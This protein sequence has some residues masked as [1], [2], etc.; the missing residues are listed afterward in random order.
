MRTQ[1]HFRVYADGV[2][3]TD[4]ESVQTATCY[5]IYCC[6]TCTCWHPICFRIWNE[7]RLWPCCSLYGACLRPAASFSVTFWNAQPNYTSLSCHV[8]CMQACSNG[9]LL[10]LHQGQV[11]LTLQLLLQLLKAMPHCPPSASA[12]QVTCCALPV[13]C[14]HASDVLLLGKHCILLIGICWP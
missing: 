5:I 12:L 4:A 11:Q 13:V 10:S 1:L 9:A 6:L 2:G 14:I 8:D 7:I 3:A